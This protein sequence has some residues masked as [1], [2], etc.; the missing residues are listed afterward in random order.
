MANVDDDFKASQP[1]SIPTVL[2]AEDFDAETDA[3][4]LHKAMKGFGTDE[5]TIIKI[6]SSRSTDQ[7]KEISSKFVASFGRKLVDELKS[8]LK[9]NL[10]QAVIGRFLSPPELEATYLMKA[11]KGLGTSEGLL[12]DILCTKTNKEIL[13]LKEA[14]QSLF[15]RDLEKDVVDEVSGDLEKILFSVLQG[16]RSEPDVDDDLAEKE[17]NDL[18]EAGEGQLG[19]RESTFNRVFALRSFPQLRATFAAYKKQ[20]GG[21]IHAAITKEFSGTTEMAFLTIFFMATN[22]VTC[23]T[24]MFHNSMKNLGTDDTALIRLVL[25]H[26]EID[27][28]TIRGRYQ[29]LYGEELSE[30]VKDETSGDYEKVLISLLDNPTE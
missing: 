8:E 13:E 9:G 17:A 20:T 3:Q 22:P 27:M 10:E 6:V 23:Y 19:T 24:R 11:M 2:P 5:E 14:Y 25:S 18:Y 30:R 4:A 12:V 15:E 1:E 26:C 16:G 21:S 7:L 29:A 28:L